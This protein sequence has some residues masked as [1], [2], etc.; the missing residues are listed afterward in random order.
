LRQ[1]CP[2]GTRSLPAVQRA[3]L[4]RR[5][6]HRARRGGERRVHA[7]GYGLAA[8]EISGERLAA[9]IER[10]PNFERKLAG[11]RQDGNLDLLGA[12]ERGIAAAV[13]SRKRRDVGPSD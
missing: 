8:D 2:R 4:H 10:L 5:S 6:S 1:G 12:L 13:A 7:H 9:F 3:W 11:Y